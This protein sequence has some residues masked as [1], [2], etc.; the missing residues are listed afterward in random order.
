MI[1]HKHKCIF[2]HAP[3]TAGTSI[4]VSLMNDSIIE[5]ETDEKHWNAEL[6]KNAY[7]EYWDKYFK[8]SVVRN[9]WDR[10]VSMHLYFTQYEKIDTVKNMSFSQWVDFSFVKKKF[11][12]M[13]GVGSQYDFLKV[14]G[15]IDLDYIL[16]YENL[17]SD[18]KKL[19]EFL[20]IDSLALP[21]YNGRFKNYSKKN[22]RHYTEYYDDETRQIVAEKYAKDIEYFGYKF[23]K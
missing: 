17:D 16:R 6:C 22:R 19:C 12:P 3:K 5:N 23:G 20:K 1:N 10:A 14:G 9:S 15:S 4:S 2:I 18:F 8:F 21:Q 7:S 11:H 13:G